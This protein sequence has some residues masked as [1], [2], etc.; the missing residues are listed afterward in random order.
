MLR[1][2]P[3]RNELAA[4]GSPT[5]DDCTVKR[6]E[7]FTFFRFDYRVRWIVRDTQIKATDVLKDNLTLSIGDIFGHTIRF[8]PI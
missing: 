8:H 3:S 6:R 5:D 2:Y 1:H 4:A 7:T